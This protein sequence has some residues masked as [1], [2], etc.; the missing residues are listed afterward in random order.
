M[1]PYSGALTE[2]RLQ[3]QK[4]CFR[5]DPELEVKY[6]AVIEDCVVKA[7][8]RRLNKNKT[9]AVSNITWYFPHHPVRNPNKPWK[10][11]VVFDAAAKY[12]GTSLN[13]QLLQGT[14][15]LTGVLIRLR[16]EEE[17]AFSAD[18]ESMFYHTSVMPSDTDAL[19]FLWWSASIE[20]R[21]EDYKMLVHIFG[22]K[23]SPCFANK[24]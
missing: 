18:V 24:A 12:N 9:A 4:R 3:Y 10:I 11:R 16:E 5:R 6:R 23:S 15:D 20:N 22:A 17:V 19:R 14:N 21:P 2:A 13:D 8:T 7:Y 1:L